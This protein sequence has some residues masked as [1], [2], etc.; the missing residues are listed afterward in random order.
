MENKPASEHQEIIPYLKEQIKNLE[1]WNNELRSV[2]K[3]SRHETNLAKLE[4][5]KANEKVSCIS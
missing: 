5:E 4:A 1:N 2:F 3:D